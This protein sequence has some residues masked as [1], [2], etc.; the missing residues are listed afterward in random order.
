MCKGLDCGTWL[1]DVETDPELYRRVAEVVPRPGWRT[2]TWRPR[3]P[4]HRD[5]ITWD[6]IIHS[7]ADIEALPFP[8]RMVNIK[9]SRF[10]SLE[11]LTAAYDYCGE[12][13]LEPC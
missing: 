2:P 7:I 11:A 5:R 8:P 1:V 3:P 10:G 13:R 6:A 4:P 12:K 9:P